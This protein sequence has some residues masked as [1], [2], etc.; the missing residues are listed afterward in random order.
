MSLS[1]ISEKFVI[2]K[3]KMINQGN[4]KLVNYDGKVYHFGDLESDLSADINIKNPNFFLNIILGGS[5]AFGEAHMNKDFYSSNLTKFIELAARNIDLINK[6]SGSVKLQT[7][8]NL[9]R[10]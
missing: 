5:S 4:L 8:K 10:M 2:N 9:P 1:K 3:L 7:I 6:F